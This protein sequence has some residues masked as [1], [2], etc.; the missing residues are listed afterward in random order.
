AATIIAEALGAM[1]ERLTSAIDGNTQAIHHLGDRIVGA[2]APPAV[3]SGPVPRLPG[4]GSRDPDA[5]AAEPMREP[6]W[7]SGIP[8][9][10]MP[11]GALADVL[12]IEFGRPELSRD[13]L[14]AIARDAG[15]LRQ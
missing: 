5:A 10:A 7:H 6:I 2:L 3:D 4:Q 15:L 9:G 14:F 11:F 1:D 12:S 8:D 13:Q